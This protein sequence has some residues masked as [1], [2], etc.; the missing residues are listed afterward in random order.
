MTCTSVP[1]VPSVCAR[2]ACLLSREPSL[3]CIV[4]VVV[5]VIAAAVVVVVVVRVVVVVVV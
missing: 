2:G 5:V 1:C 3:R 4:V